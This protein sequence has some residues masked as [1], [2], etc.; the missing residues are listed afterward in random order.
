MKDV[1]LFVNVGS[2]VN[3]N[4]VHVTFIL[5]GVTYDYDVPFLETYNGKNHYVL[6]L[7]TGGIDIFWE[8]TNEWV[9]N[10]DGFSYVNS[11]DSTYPIFDTWTFSDGDFE[12]DSLVTTEYLQANYKQLELFNDENIDITSTIQ[13]VQDIS[14]VFTDFSQGFTI[15]ASETNRQI[16]GH[17]E[18]SSI[19][20]LYDYQVSF[21]SYIEIDTI[22]F[23]K[24]KLKI[25]KAQVQNGKLY[26]YNVQFVGNLTQLIDL[27][28]ELKISDLDLSPYSFEYNGTEIQ[29]RLTDGIT[30]YD[31]RFPLIS[32]NRTWTYGDTTANDIST[33]VGSLSIGELL[34]AIKLKAIMQAIQT[35][36]SIAFNSVFF[37]TK[38]FDRAFLYLKNASNSSV[39]FD[40]DNLTFDTSSGSTNFRSIDGN[41]LTY[42]YGNITL[43]G[44][45]I[46]SYKYQT[47]INVTSVTDSTAFIAIQCYNNGVLV[48]TIQF[49][50]TGEKVIF[51]QQ[52]T[53]GLESNLTFKINSETSNTIDLEVKNSMIPTLGGYLPTA[54]D[55]FTI[56]CNTITPGLNINLNA[57]CPDIKI[58]EFF[59]GVLKMF[60]LTIEPLSATTFKIETLEDWYSK[61]KITDVTAH[62]SDEAIDI[63]R[64]KLYNNVAFNNQQSNTLLNRAF[65]GINQ[66]EYGDLR[67]TF[68]NDGSEF[69]IQQPFEN[70]LFNKFTDTSIQVSYCVDSDSKPLTP[71]PIILYMNDVVDITATTIK[72]YNDVTFVDLES[73]LPFGQDVVWNE[74]NYSLNWGLEISSYY[75]TTINNSLFQTYWSNYLATLYD[76]RQ[77]LYRYDLLLPISKIYNLKLN[78]RLVIGDKRYLIN[79]IKTTVTNGLSQVTLLQDF[80]NVSNNIYFD[81]TND[82]TCLEVPIFIPNGATSFEITTGVSGVTITPSTATEDTLVTICLP[83]GGT[84]YLLTESGDYITTESGDRLIL[85]E[86]SSGTIT[87]TITYNT[88]E[89]KQI[90]ITRNA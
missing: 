50:G 55:T 37:Q 8:I 59:S 21:E 88:G 15:P 18:E 25:D 2:E 74:T 72:F 71:R 48:N 34:P 13:N 84:S 9:L 29:N 60:N 28:G 10:G 26:C 66:S 23:K 20:Q 65:F 33:I 78:D 89:T 77:R 76:L 14:K 16:L 80:R 64:V 85:E 30:D 44:N 63:E 47:S 43:F 70:I 56:V 53:Y 1:G 24:G 39:K 11:T 19:T 17:F 54:V 82:A 46:T 49:Q 75:L 40:F 61:G 58:S 90:I 38:L 27:F 81:I 67:N 83:V 12:L 57:L 69:K 36:F 68:S 45:T 4:F 3:H 32:S 41:T 73:Y 31:V 87:L 35:K 7:E 62:T 5:D 22:P 51:E 52:N 86:S 42:T 6:I 79:D